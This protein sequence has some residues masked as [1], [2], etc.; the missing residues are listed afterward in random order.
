MLIEAIHRQLSSEYL[1]MMENRDLP[2]KPVCIIFSG[3]P[4]S[5][6]TTLARKLAQ[7]LSA[8]YIRH[9]DIRKLA[10][11]HGYDVTKLTISSISRIVMDTIMENDA[12]KL[13]IVDASLDR[14]WP[15]FF[16]YTTEHGALPIVIRL[17]IPRPIIEQRIHQRDKDDFGYITN[18]DEF[19]AQ[20][21]NSKKH[22][23]ATMTLGTDYDY[24]DVLRGMKE[25][26]R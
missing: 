2:Q 11:N 3:V 10:R 12:N 5:G 15:L 1:H 17:D 19:Y 20:L 14:T 7:D 6:K 23:P 18:L 16:E 24:N 8:Q 22:V 25:L 26:I 4:G 13:V 9:D 21:E